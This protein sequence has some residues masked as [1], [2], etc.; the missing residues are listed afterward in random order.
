MRYIGS[1]ESLTGPIIQLLNEKG[2]LQRNYVF[3]DAFCGMGA[4]AD[5]VKT[6]YDHIIINDSLKCSSTF[7]SGKLLANLV[8]ILL[9]ILMV[10]RKLYKDLCTKIILQDVLNECTSLLQTQVG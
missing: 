6:T 1:K 3:F 7:A 10:M 5:A 4:V 9:I 2:L 8:L